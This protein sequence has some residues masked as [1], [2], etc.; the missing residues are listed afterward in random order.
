MC[1]CTV[2]LQKLLQVELLPGKREEF[3]AEHEYHIT[4]TTADLRYHPS[5]CSY[6]VSSIFAPSCQNRPLLT[7]VMV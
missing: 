2:T 3:I 5:L 1:F 6:P 7:V 4:V